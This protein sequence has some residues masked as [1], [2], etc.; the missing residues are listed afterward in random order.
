MDE[1]Q[2][3]DYATPLSELMR[4]VADLSARVDEH[5]KRGGFVP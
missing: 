1:S 5:L 4:E 3:K 2:H